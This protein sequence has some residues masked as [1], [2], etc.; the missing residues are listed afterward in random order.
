MFVSWAD[1]WIRM[2]TAENYHESGK[3]DCGQKVGAARRIMGS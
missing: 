3:C 1:Q 2:H